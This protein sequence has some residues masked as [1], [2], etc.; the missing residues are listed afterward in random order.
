ML[1]IFFTILVK[2]LEINKY[3]NQSRNNQNNQRWLTYFSLKASCING[4][5]NANDN[6]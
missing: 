3:W 6:V 5:T 1:N 2:I 4:I